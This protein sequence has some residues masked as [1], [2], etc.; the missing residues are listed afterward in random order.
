MKKKKKEKKSIKINQKQFEFFKKTWKMHTST[1]IFKSFTYDSSV[2]RI[3]ETT[4]LYKGDFPVNK[5]SIGCWFCVVVVVV[6]VVCDSFVVDVDDDVVV[7]VVT[8]SKL[9]PNP[10]WEIFSSSFFS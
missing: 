1:T 10:K 3:S 9:I 6:V 4:F 2:V 7:V 5:S 8:S